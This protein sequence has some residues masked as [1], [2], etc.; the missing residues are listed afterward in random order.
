MLQVNPGD[1]LA[2]KKNLVICRDREVIIENASGKGFK[3]WPRRC[4]PPDFSIFLAKIDKKKTSPDPEPGGPRA[5]SPYIKG[6]LATSC[7]IIL[8]N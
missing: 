1:Y 2:Q 6:K 5:P 7:D 3:N 4:A 8:K